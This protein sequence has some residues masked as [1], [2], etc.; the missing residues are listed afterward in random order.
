[1]T[2]KR[3][4]PILGTL[5]TIG[6]LSASAF[7]GPVEDAALQSGFNSWRQNGKNFPLAQLKTWL[8]ATAPK[9]IVG[10]QGPMGLQGPPGPQGIAGAPAVIPP[11]DA[12]LQ[13]A[14]QNWLA[15]QP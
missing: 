4:F 2:M 8:A 10:P 7:S 5:L 3:I 15:V 1:M 9:S 12:A 6:A 11:L 13:T 14:L